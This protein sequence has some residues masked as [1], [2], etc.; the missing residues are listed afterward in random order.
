M[1]NDRSTFRFDLNLTK[2]PISLFLGVLLQDR[3]PRLLCHMKPQILSQHKPCLRIYCWKR[4][5]HN[6]C[7][8]QKQPLG[9][10]DYPGVGA[11]ILRT[12]REERE[13]GHGRDK[14]T[15]HRKLHK[16]FQRKR[17][18]LE[19]RLCFVF[20]D[21][22]RQPTQE[23]HDDGRSSPRIHPFDVIKDVS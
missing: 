12:A 9:E 18:G 15:N 5:K 3:L 11:H 7:Y 16:L 4:T 8:R 1:W 13:G 6:E 21:P 23:E 14:D 10:H 20:S 22:Q 19:K 17:R 2:A